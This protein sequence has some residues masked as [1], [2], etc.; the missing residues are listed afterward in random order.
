M[1]DEFDERRE[2][3]MVSDTKDTFV[4]ARK[5]RRSKGIRALK[6]VLREK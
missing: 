2:K 1:A 4:R 5:G 3:G 6:A